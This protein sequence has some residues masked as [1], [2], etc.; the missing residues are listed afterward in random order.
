[1]DC[2]SCRDF[3]NLEEV[4]PGSRRKKETAK[5]W[6][7]LNNDRRK[8]SDITIQIGNYKKELCV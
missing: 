1:V 8:L 3:D 2:L 5:T 7:I 4:L 6:K